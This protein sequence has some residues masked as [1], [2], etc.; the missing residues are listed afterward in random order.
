[1]KRNDAERS[2]A[3][4]EFL[5]HWSARVYDEAQ[6]AQIREI[7]A[8][9]IRYAMEGWRPMAIPPPEDVLLI[10]ATDEGL[11]LM[12][13][14]QMGDWRTNGGVPQRAPRAWMPAP[15]PPKTNG[16]G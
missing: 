1:M 3:E 10:C 5:R 14:T 8:H 11:M 13:K 6:L 4:D 2:D 12:R 15:V 9:L 16:K 7:E